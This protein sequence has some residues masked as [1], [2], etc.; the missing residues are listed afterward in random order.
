MGNWNNKN[1][2]KKCKVCS[3]ELYLDRYDNV[4]CPYCQG[5]KPF[6]KSESLEICKELTK[7][8]ES[9]INLMCNEFSYDYLL[10]FGCEFRE[11]ETIH[12][13]KNLTEFRIDQIIEGT[14]FLKKVL[15][16]FHEKKK[17]A[18]YTRVIASAGCSF[19]KLLQEIR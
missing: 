18:F 2:N 8:V 7:F 12:E 14:I 4:L 3:S 16:S 5:F 6:S 19:V 13:S 17:R 1:T 15:E 9:K 11:F 10:K